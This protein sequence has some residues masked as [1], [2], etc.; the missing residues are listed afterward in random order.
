MLSAG[1]R[2]MTRKL[3]VLELPHASVATAVT[4]LVPWVNKE[5]DGGDEA[6][7]TELQVSVAVMDQLTAIFVQQVRTRIL[8]GQMIV[9]GMV[10]LMVTVWL[11]LMLLVQQSLASQVRVI[12]H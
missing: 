4:V 8:D 6:T 1:R 3:Q 11:Q 10:S 5:P 9:G 2:T 7:V 12:W